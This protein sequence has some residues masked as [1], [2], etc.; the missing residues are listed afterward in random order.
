MG[1]RD[2]GWSSSVA[3]WAHNP[4]VAGSNPA[5]AT[6]CAGQRPLPIPGGAFLLWRANEFAN[7]LGP[8]T[9][10]PF[11]PCLQGSRPTAIAEPSGS[12]VAAV[13]CRVP[14]RCGRLARQQLVGRRHRAAAGRWPRQR[15]GP[16]THTGGLE[17]SEMRLYLL[18]SR[19][20]H[21]TA[22]AG[23]PAAGNPAAVAR[24]RECLLSS[25]QETTGLVLAAVLQVVGCIRRCNRGCSRRCRPGGPRLHPSVLPH[26]CPQLQAAHVGG[27]HPD[28][29]ECVCDA[30]G[31][32]VGD[33]ELR[34]GGLRERCSRSSQRLEVPAGVEPEADRHR[35][36]GVA[37]PVIALASQMRPRAT[38]PR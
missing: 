31:Q 6:K 13:A 30:A 28:R 29:Q 4:E 21:G 15:L 25:D 19:L 22:P 9:F 26:P 38:R 24:L 10:L 23:Y 35:P 32:P 3:R 1:T 14:R 2:A 36:H 27:W 37:G 17:S 12:L 34:V 7:A 33:V 5:P 18:G 11:Y 16:V 8:V 20:P